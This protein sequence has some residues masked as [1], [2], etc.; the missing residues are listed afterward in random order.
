MGQF[1]I[2]R[3]GTV[4]KHFTQEIGILIMNGLGQKSPSGDNLVKI[5]GGSHVRR[6]GMI[7]F[8][9]FIFGHI[10]D[11]SLADNL[12][13]VGFMEPLIAKAIFCNRNKALQEMRVEF[14]KGNSCMVVRKT[15][16]STVDTVVKTST[17]LPSKHLTVG[18][19]TNDSATK[20]Q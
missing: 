8:V 10:R 13:N 4:G 16:A 15:S 20:I 19:E 11:W 7:I 5:L 6:T 14:K 18:Q 9:N 12:G 2:R 1:Q 3:G 17:L